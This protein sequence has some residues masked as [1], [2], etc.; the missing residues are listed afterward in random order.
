MVVSLLA[1]FIHS[2]SLGKP[3]DDPLHVDYVPSIFAFKRNARSQSERQNERHLR[4]QQRRGK[5]AELEAT[6]A[7]AEA[8]VNMNVESP[9]VHDSATT[10]VSTQT[11]SAST[12]AQC[13]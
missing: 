1:S 12:V 4:L 8:L 7:A 9:N 2:T 11:V 3:S 6:T 13:V 5:A 10:N